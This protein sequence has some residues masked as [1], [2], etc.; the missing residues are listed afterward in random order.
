MGCLLTLQIS[1]MKLAAHVDQ[2]ASLPVHTTH[3]LSVAR[4][5]LMSQQIIN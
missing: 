1:S 3:I 4:N 5:L 2:A